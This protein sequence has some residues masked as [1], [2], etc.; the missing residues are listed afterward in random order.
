MPH[1]VLTHASVVPRLDEAPLLQER[2]AI[3][4]VVETARAPKGW[5]L[6]CI[7]VRPQHAPRR[8]LARLDERADGLVAHL[9]DHVSVER[10]EDT[11]R[12]LA[13]VAQAVLRANPQATVGKTNLERWLAAAHA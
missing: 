1:A 6:K 11:F 10:D 9:D 13:L 2:G 12:F 5:L 3:Y 8:F 4:R 7:I